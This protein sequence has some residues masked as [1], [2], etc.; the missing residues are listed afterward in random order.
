VFD[1]SVQVS[2]V[3][4]DV[5]ASYVQNKALSEVA[6]RQLEQI[7]LKK[8]EVA[9]NDSAIRRAEEEVASLSQD[10][11][12]LRSNIESLSR[13][14]G[15]QDQVQQYARQLAA[16]ETRLAALRDTQSDLRKKKATL[17]AE[18]NSLMERIEF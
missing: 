4:P 16:A 12:R 13:V 6:R 15:Q 3:T 7:A 2:S 5:L 1:Q 14:N 18:L 10:Q 11:G 8:R 9:A 17:D